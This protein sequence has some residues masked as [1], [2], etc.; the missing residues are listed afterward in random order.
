MSAWRQGKVLSVL[1]A[2][3][4]LAVAG[5][6]AAQ[7]PSLAL[8]QEAVRLN[9]FV[10]ELVNTQCALKAGRPIEFRFENPRRGWIFV[11]VSGN[12]PQNGVLV[13][14]DPATGGAPTRLSSE[15][16][17]APLEMM[18]LLPPGEHSVS[19]RSEA[20][21]SISLIVR[22]IP[23]LHFASF[24][25]DPHVT[26]YGPYDW[27]Y[28][29]RHVLR[30][31]NCIIGQGDAAERPLAE[32]WRKQGKKW[33]AQC[34]FP[35]ITESPAGALTAEEI[36]RSW[37]KLPGY[38]DPA[39]D[40]V[41]ADEIG[42]NFPAAQIDAYTNAIRLIS[43]NEAHKGQVFYPYCYDVM[44]RNEAGKRFVE[45]VT[46]AGGQIAW[47]RYVNETPTEE[48]AQKA[49]EKSLKQDLLKWEEAIPGFR[50]HIIVALGYFSMITATSEAVYPG[51]NYKM[52]MDMQFHMLATDPAL[53]G[54]YGVQE[55][56]CG[57]A[58][59]ETVRWASRLYRHYCIEGN[60]EMLSKR[61]GFTYA[62][63]H[64]R[65]PDF[66]H[67]TEGWEIKAAEAG[68]AGAK[69]FPGYGRFEGRWSEKIGDNFLW[70]KRSSKGPNIVRQ[71][72]R[73]LTPGKLYS[74]KLVTGDYGALQ[75]GKSQNSKQALS[76][77][78][79]DVTPLP[80][81]SFV[82]IRPNHKENHLGAFDGKNSFY[83]NYHLKV[84]RA[85]QTHA[86]LTISDWQTDQ[87]PGGP[88]G[89][90]LMYNFVDVQPYFDE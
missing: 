11:A 14:L 38:A 8:A 84:F 62:P 32:E 4:A 68:S 65:N 1:L 59:D 34:N 77:S 27:K 42:A 28:L 64:L 49:I 37:L 75:A 39:F 66:D 10:T 5:G 86:T 81:K 16:G 29:S 21:A 89:Q 6:C 82:E 79:S 53:A 50:E 51:V 57:Y 87:D 47:E 17:G 83:F 19:L 67:G 88:A 35:G 70:T 60:T 52:H 30:N 9:N 33:L 44:T 90:E 40:G 12:P 63:D 18:R 55:Y 72:I 58:D 85:N 54:L 25:Y 26:S 43:E 56:T 71:E 46:G 69:S 7:A 36:S 23:E 73:N 2:A 3:L 74:M 24:Q 41:I 76:V 22:T 15:A 13:T 78:L 48:E 31:V 20:A 80:E 61:Y 45:T